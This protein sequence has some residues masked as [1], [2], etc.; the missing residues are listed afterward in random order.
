MNITILSNHDIASIYALDRLLRGLSE[1]NIQVFMSAHVGKKDSH[2]PKSLLALGA[3]DNAL[4]KH[5]QSQRVIARD[6]NVDIE[7]ATP[8]TAIATRLHV[9]VTRLNSVNTAS[10]LALL[11]KTQADLF[12]SIRFGLILHREAI[13]L[14]KRGVMNLHSGILPDYKG[15]MATFWAMKHGEKNIGTTLHYIRDSQIDSGDIITVSQRCVD[16]QRSY[17]WNTLQL[18]PQGCDDII[19]AVKALSANKALT[20]HRQTLAGRYYSFPAQHD[21]DAFEN[22]GNVLFK[23]GDSLSLFEKSAPPPNHAPTLR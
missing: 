21:I 10:S 16:Y 9:P 18:Y 15:V 20:H 3:F 8:F 6:P 11:D 2:A 17:L 13:G 23:E 22:Q 19:C 4:V 1:H 12:I 7:P 14:A 5:W